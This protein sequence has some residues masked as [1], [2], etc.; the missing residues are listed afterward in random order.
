MDIWKFYDITHRFHVLC[1]PMSCE[2]LDGLVRLLHLPADAR[3]VEI[4]TGKGEF[5]IRLAEAYD[6][7]SGIGVDISPYC[8]ADAEKK[9]SMRLPNAR[10]RFKTM[11]GAKFASEVQESFALGACIGASWIFGGHR[12][13]LE[14]LVAMVKPDG[15]IVVG[16]PFWL[17]EPSAAYLEAAELSSDSFGSHADNVV[18]GEKLGLR[19]THTIVS[20]ADDW[21]EYEGLTWYAADRHARSHPEDPDVPALL[22]R[23]AKEKAAY[24]NWGRGTVG[25]AIYA[26]RKP[27]CGSLPPPVNPAANPGLESPLDSAGG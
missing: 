21:D 14:A 4:A 2:K 19:L 1:N 13:T 10:L 11:D 6:G 3:V 8:I 9:L 27:S 7:I 22:D 12:R 15:W 18:I 26:F 20:N 5:I 23:V 17:R 16:E 25:W 24:L